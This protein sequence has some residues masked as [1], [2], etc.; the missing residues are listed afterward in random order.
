MADRSPLLNIDGRQV[1]ADAVLDDLTGQIAEAALRLAGARS[2]ARQAL[3]VIQ[4]LQTVA[5]PNP[6]DHEDEPRDVMMTLCEMA[7][8]IDRGRSTAD[9]GPST[10]EF[11]AA[12]SNACSE[13]ARIHHPRPSE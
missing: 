11:W 6:D 12:F 3:M 8:R 7:L 9:T 4:A 1:P 5:C 10:P 13:Y 2:D